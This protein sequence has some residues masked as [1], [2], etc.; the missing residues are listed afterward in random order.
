MKH[1]IRVG[2]A[3]KT[4][5]YTTVT[6]T[7]IVSGTILDITWSKDAINILK[8]LA[9]DYGFEY[10]KAIDCI[11]MT[12]LSA[13]EEEGYL[14]VKI[15]RQSL[16]PVP[17]LQDSKNEPG[18]YTQKLGIV[19]TVDLKGLGLACDYAWRTKDN[20][21]CL[22]ERKEIHD[23]IASIVD[24]RLR[25]ELADMQRLN[26]DMGF[27]LIEGPM[28]GRDSNGN[29]TTFKNKGKYP[30]GRTYAQIWGALAT[31]QAY[32]PRLI[33]WYSP[34]GFATPDI[35]VDM[36]KWS[37]K[38][39][40]SSVQDELIDIGY[41]PSMT[42]E[43]ILLTALPGVKSILAKRLMEYYKYP[44]AALTAGTVTELP[45]TFVKDIRKSVKGI[46]KK[47][48]EAIKDFLDGRISY[49]VA[50]WTSEL[51]ELDSK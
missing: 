10:K 42:K 1:I 27:L 29:P 35:L 7:D 48:A 6:A 3:L 28:M 4:N 16:K 5:G 18:E 26:V 21:L 46:G 32:Y 51:E 34:G 12:I 20:R 43:E 39:H 25:T 2:S 14:P 9:L 31:F 30:F 38:T 8:Q 15:L 44:I 41:A 49:Q 11:G 13:S 24:G 47:K 45:D 36:Y 19:A 22:V 33:L 40:H 37:N 23:L 17:I 50:Q